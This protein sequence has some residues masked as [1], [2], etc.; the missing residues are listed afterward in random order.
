M[1]RR[2]QAA[3]CNRISQTTL[4]WIWGDGWSRACAPDEWRAAEK[5]DFPTSY[6]DRQH[7]DH[8]EMPPS[9]FMPVTEIFGL[10]IHLGEW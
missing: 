3:F 9:I 10:V 1:L 6:Q 4:I 7:S 8:G 2:Q 5:V